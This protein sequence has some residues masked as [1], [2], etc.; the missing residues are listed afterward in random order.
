MQ[1]AAAHRTYNDRLLEAHMRAGVT[2]IDPATTWVDADVHLAPDV[3]LLPSV[4]LHGA[5]V[6]GTARRSGRTSP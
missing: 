3:T 4:Q 2:V 5:T 6:V 1:L